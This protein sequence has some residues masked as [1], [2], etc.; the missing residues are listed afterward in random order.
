[1]NHNVQLEDKELEDF[2]LEEGDTAVPLEIYRSEQ[3]EQYEILV[4]P[5]CISTVLPILESGA[6]LF[7]G[8]VLDSLARS[9]NPLLDS[10]SF[11]PSPDGISHI[12]EFKM[13]SPSDVPASLILPDTAIFLPAED[14]EEESVSACH[15]SD[16]K[17]VAEAAPNDYSDDD[18][19]EIH[20][21]C[22]PEY[23]GKG[24]ATSCVAK[25]TEYYLKNGNSVRYHCRMQNKASLRIPK[26]CG[27]TLQGKRVSFVYY[28]RGS[29]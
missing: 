26:K 29:L 4:Y 20:V 11:V 3:A 6:D 1:M 19:V 13:D 8:A 5:C 15:I 27:F 23:R 24:Y 16:G 9:L 25:L 14:S 18:S 22:L 28:R 12:C 2:I 21:Q 17:P 10:F 7:D